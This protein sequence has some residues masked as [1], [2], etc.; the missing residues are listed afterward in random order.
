[1]NAEPLDLRRLSQFKVVADVAGFSGAAEILHLSQQA[2]SSAIVRFESDLGCTLFERTTR[3]VTLTP[4]GRALRAGADAL[5]AASEA[6]RRQVA[7]AA[8]L[9][10]TPFV[11]GHSPAISAAEVHDLLTSVRKG[12]PAQPIT[13]T[14]VFPPELESG[15]LSGR[16]DVALRRGVM[17]PGQFAATVIGYSTVRLAVP[18]DHRFAARPEIR[19]RDLR[20]EAIVTWAPVGSSFYTDFI[21]GTCRRAG[22]EPAIVVNRVQGTPPATAVLDNDAVAFVT[23][24]PGPLFD[25]RVMVLELVDAPMAP[26]QAVWLRGTVSIARDLLVREG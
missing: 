16:L 7:D 4:A 10:T 12:L 19:V 5:L 24:P 15:L 26:V 3:R 20:D 23:D 14:Q 9:H 1:M 6:L 2:V 21:I 18:A 22:F 13:V 17:A 8:S 25:G 11:V